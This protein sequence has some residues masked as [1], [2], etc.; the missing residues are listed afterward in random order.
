MSSP[1]RNKLLA[2]SHEYELLGQFTT[3]PFEKEF[4]KLR[5]HTVQQYIEKLHI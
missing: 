4:S 1:F 3:D 2:T 5:Q